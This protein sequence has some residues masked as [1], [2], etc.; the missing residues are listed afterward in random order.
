MP[1]SMVSI[2]VTKGRVNEGAIVSKFKVPRKDMQS[3][4]SMG[5]VVKEL[6]KTFCR[7][8]NILMRNDALAPKNDECMTRVNM[9]SLPKTNDDSGQQLLFIGHLVDNIAKCESYCWKDGK[10][11]FD[12]NIIHLYGLQNK[13]DTMQHVSIHKWKAH[14]NCELSKQP[15]WKEVWCK[16]RVGKINAFLWQVVFRAPTTNQWR[17][18]NTPHSQSCNNCKRCNQNY[19]DCLLECPK[20]QKV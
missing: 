9:T 11:L 13:G 5:Q 15:L 8:R 4:Y 2:F 17:F 16:F 14:T 1:R 18:S 20:A 12:T 19:M 7:S 3:S 10:N 6:P